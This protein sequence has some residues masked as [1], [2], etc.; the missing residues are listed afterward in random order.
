MEEEKTKT[1]PSDPTNNDDAVITSNDNGKKDEHENVVKQNEKVKKRGEKRKLN[2]SERQNGSHNGAEDHLI[3]TD[4]LEH[5]DS[6]DGGSKEHKD[7]SGESASDGAEASSNGCDE[8]EGADGGSD[9]D[10]ASGANHNVEGNPPSK[11]ETKETFYSQTKFEDLDICEALKKGLKELNF[12]TLTEI[13]AKCIPH[14]LNGKDILGAAKTGSG[15]T[16][17]FLV[18]SINIL[19]NIK[20][21]PKNGTGVLI[22]S[23][24]RELCLQIYQVCKDLCK[25]IPQT[26]GIIIGGMSRNEE[27]KKFIHGI[28]ILIATPGRL[29]DHMQN[30]KEFIYKNLI[31]LIIDEADRLLQI[32]FEEEI[33]LI[34]K[35]L[36]KKRQTALFSA[37]QTTKVENLIRLSLQKPIFIEV[38]TKIATVERLQ[39]GYALVDEDKRFLLLFTFLKRNI[40]KKIMVFFNNCMSVQF[41]NDLLNYIDIPTF[42]IHG[43]K[44]QNKRL[45]SFS[46]FSA[47][48]SAILLC[49]N[50]AARGLDIPNVNYII[51]YDPPDDSKEYIHRVGRTCRGKDSSGSAIIFLMKHELK[52]LN[53]L[54]F[55]NIPINQFAYDPSK[56]INVQSHIESIVTK[57]FHLHKMAREAF[58]SYL[59]GYITYALKDVFDVN[60]LNLLLT[61]KNFGL[62]APPKVDLNLKLNVKKR[63]FK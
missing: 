35:R 21:L 2:S 33:N 39:Q 36:P 5:G 44:K 57:N 63:K 60:N 34:V 53:Y 10:A 31:S 24:T 7:G 28:N 52:F 41:Y 37:T 45:K 62:E 15:K 32:G 26:N 58:K 42:C 49:T 29:L 25:Y 46:E 47:A 43:K 19:Y 38:T 11:V 23:P 13:Q 17:A 14:F 12:V 8:Q 18:P 30:T 61:S 50:V 9:A 27:K 48:Q 1:E 40:S 54:K 59:N 22:I 20:F 3:S 51:Q 4:E 56:L 16:L 55:Y 6:V